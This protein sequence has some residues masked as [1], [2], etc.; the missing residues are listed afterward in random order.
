[1][2]PLLPD[3]VRRSLMPRDNDGPTPWLSQQAT[4]QYGVTPRRALDR[5]YSGRRGHK[6][7]DA[8]VGAVAN[9]GAWVGDRFADDVLEL[10]HP[11]LYR[12]LVEFA[13]GLPPGNVRSTPREKV[14]PARSNPGILPEAVRTRVGKAGG[15]GMMLR[16]VIRDR[17]LLLRLLR[18]PLLAQLGCIEPKLLREAVENAGNEQR[19]PAWLSSR[20][21]IA[22]ET[23]LWLQ[24]RAGYPLG[25][26][27]QDVGGTH[28]PQPAR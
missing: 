7:A 27:T 1:M 26:I 19:V 6:Y 4:R 24:I 2:L 16:S 25:N 23:E 18:N 11:F 14:D 15:R 10:R 9:S 12:P 13:L 3:G 21:V 22:I 8:L 28:A 20:A 5:A 17:T